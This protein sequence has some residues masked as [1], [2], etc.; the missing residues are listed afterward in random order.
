MGNS[1]RLIMHRRNIIQSN[2]KLHK[3]TKCPRLWHN[4][5]VKKK[6][7]IRNR[8]N[9]IL[10]LTWDIIWKSDK[11]TRK[12][13]RQESKEVRPMGQPFSADDYK[14]ARNIQDSTTTNTH[15]M[16]ITKRIHKRST[17]LEPTVKIAVTVSVGKLG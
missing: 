3:L 14:T 17:A 9:Q 5:K 8:Y 13:H 16:K 15:E 1:I 2:L 7:K 6:A 11:N 4:S 12:H 10:H